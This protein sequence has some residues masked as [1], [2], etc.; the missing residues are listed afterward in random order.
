MALAG[1]VIYPPI[2]KKSKAELDDI[3]QRSFELADKAKNRSNFFHR[4]FGLTDPLVLA[5]YF[6]LVK[7]TKSLRS[8]KLLWDNRFYQDA[9]VIARTIFDS[10]I[11]ATYM[12]TRPENRVA[13]RTF[14]EHENFLRYDLSKRVVRSDQGV[15][16]AWLI[17]IGEYEQAYK[18]SKSKF[19]IQGGWSGKSTRQMARELE[20][21]GYSG[22]FS[23]YEFL[24]PILSGL[25]HSNSLAIQEYFQLKGNS[26]SHK[27]SRG[28]PKYFRI[29]PYLAANWSG[30]IAFMFLIE[31][32]RPFKDLVL[33][34]TLLALETLLWD[35]KIILE[36]DAAHERRPSILDSLSKGFLNVPGQ[37]TNEIIA[38]ANGT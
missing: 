34:D 15:N 36:P 22:L 26:Y 12:A 14:F 16:R 23:D 1:G 3:F 7:A 28:C 2:M 9:A 17:Q 10:C 31:Q 25:T 19:D 5:L 33:F 21:G 30:C 11:N 29:V 20:E 27:L 8:M 38:N 18:A 35:I 32:N 24:F 4:R 6:F 37:P 13:A